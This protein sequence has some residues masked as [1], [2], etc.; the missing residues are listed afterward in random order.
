MLNRFR[1][2]GFSLVELMVGLV[3]G[4][5]VV[6]GASAMYVSTVRGQAYALRAAKLNQDLRA[7]M[8]VIAADVRRAGYWGGAITGAGNPAPL[9]HP[10]SLA[11][12]TT[13][14][15]LTVLEAGTCLMYAYDADADASN[16]VEAGEVFGFRLAGNVIQM[17]DPGNT[18]VETDDCDAGTWAGMTSNDTVVVDALIFSTT[19][20]Q[21]LNAS[22]GISWRLTAANSVLSA[23]A[24]PVAD[25]TM[26]AG[27]TYA[28]PVSGNV[29]TEVRQL[30]ITM[31]AHH[32]SDAATASTITEVVHLGN[33]RIFSIP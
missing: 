2:T 14:T 29:L 31:T 10:Y 22:Q 15:D 26:N 21:C 3:V 19:G 30:T 27:A 23:C 4:L 25:V 7:T 5:I 17:L 28:A 8:N 16:P 9:P 18:L 20:S 12:G 13:Q 11:D 1:Q 6:A 32:Q 33:N 24:A